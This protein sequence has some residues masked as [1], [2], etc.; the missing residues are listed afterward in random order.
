[1]DTTSELLEIFPVFPICHFRQESGDFGI[2]WR[3]GWLAGIK[4]ARDAIHA[5]GDPRG[6]I[7]IGVGGGPADAV[8]DPAKQFVNCARLI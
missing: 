2:V 8:L 3:V 1:M 4:P 5:A 6:N 7:Q